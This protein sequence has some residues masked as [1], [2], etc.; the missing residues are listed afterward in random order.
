V[1]RQH[2]HLERRV[3]DAALLRDVVVILGRE[4]RHG[5]I[6]RLLGLHDV[7][8]VEQLAVPGILRDDRVG[9]GVVAHDV[10]DVARGQRPDDLL[11]QRRERNEGKV[12]LVAA[13]LL[14]FRDHGAEADVLLANEALRPPYAHGRSRRIGDVG[15]SEGAGCRKTERPAEHRTPVK[16]AHANPPCF[17]SCREFM[18]PCN[19]AE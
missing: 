1:E 19:C 9:G 17:T 15:S 5:M 13:R 2:G 8:E 18:M 6:L 12:D 10:R 3:V 7:G 11:H 16:L 4:D 14:V